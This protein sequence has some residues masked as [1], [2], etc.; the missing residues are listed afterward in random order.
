M[1]KNKM[2]CLYRSGYGEWQQSE[3]FEEDFKIGEGT[4]FHIKCG[5]SSAFYE[6][7]SD[8][9]FTDRKD[10]I[11]TYYKFETPDVDRIDNR[12]YSVASIDHRNQDITFDIHSE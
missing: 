11:K 2:K 4:H 12:F 9:Y 6:M 1:K 3:L 8:R 7:V 5:E 10:R